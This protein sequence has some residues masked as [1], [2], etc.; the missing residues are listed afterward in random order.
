MG[1]QPKRDVILSVYDINGDVLYADVTAEPATL[2]E[3]R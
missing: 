2:P 1:R 3:A